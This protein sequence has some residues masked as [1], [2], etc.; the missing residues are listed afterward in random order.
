[1]LAGDRLL[2]NVYE[3]LRMLF[4]G[5]HELHFADDFGAPD[6]PTS[7]PLGWLRPPPG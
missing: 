4:G 5:G 7:E 2:A 1:L 3:R 6:A